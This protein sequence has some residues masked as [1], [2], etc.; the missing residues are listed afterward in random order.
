[1]KKTFAL[2]LAFALMGFTLLP[3][4]GQGQRN[5]NGNSRS[6]AVAEPGELLVQF[7]ADANGADKN[8]ALAKI[9]GQELEKVKDK[10]DRSDGRGDLVLA[11]LSQLTSENA[12]FLRFTLREGA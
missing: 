1:M 12:E 3:S 11:Q 2:F 7:K 4:A 6:D 9:K 10:K 8:K 5:G